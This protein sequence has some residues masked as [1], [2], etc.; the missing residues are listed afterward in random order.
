VSNFLIFKFSWEFFFGKFSIIAS[1]NFWHSMAQSSIFGFDVSSSYLKYKH[2]TLRD[3][4]RLVL[5]FIISFPPV[6][7]K[8][9]YNVPN[10][11]FFLKILL[12]GIYIHCTNTSILFLKL[13]MT[14][15]FTTNTT[16]FRYQFF[17]LRKIKSNKITFLAPLIKC[18]PK[19]FFYFIPQAKMYK[20]DPI[21]T[22]N[23]KMFK[24]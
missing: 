23:P 22:L 12:N 13:L 7:I 5:G 1:L 2:I 21:W 6:I 14:M 24:I 18:H 3:Y 20:F 16:K 9:T 19:S 10:F 17:N 11:E 4:F 8:I 15:T